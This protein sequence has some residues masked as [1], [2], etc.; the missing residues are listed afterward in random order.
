MYRFHCIFVVNFV[1]IIYLTAT[2]ESY[3]RYDNLKRDAEEN[4][5]HLL[6]I[7][8][9]H[10]IIPDVIDDASHADLLEVRE[11]QVKSMN[12]I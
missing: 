4:D 12:S 2:V 11:N 1:I 7:L 3:H 5:H 8:K 10:E 9:D 6:N